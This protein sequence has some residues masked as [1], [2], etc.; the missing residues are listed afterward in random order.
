M[1]IEQ[2]VEI[3][4]RNRTKKYYMDKGYLFTRL[5]DIFS[6]DVKDLIGLPSVLAKYQCDFCNRVFEKRYCDLINK[7]NGSLSK[8]DCCSN[9]NF[10]KRVLEATIR[11]SNGT[12]KSGDPF[13]WYFEEN[14][15]KEL[16]EY[17]EK[18]ESLDDITLSTL[19]NNLNS[20]I[21]KYDGSLDKLLLK[22][23]YNILDFKTKN[24]YG[25]Y[26]NF[27]NLKNRIE[28]LI[29]Q[30]QRFPTLEECDAS[31]LNQFHFK[32]YGGIYE[33]KRMMGYDN[34]DDLIDDRR[35]VNR[36]S[37]EYIVAQFLIH[38][39]VAYSREQNPFPQ[40]GRNFKSDFTLYDSSN[41][42]VHIEL[43]GFE[44]NGNKEI[45]VNYRNNKL[46]KKK[47]YKKYNIHL[48]ELERKLFQDNSYH[49]INE[50]LYEIF[51][52]FIATEYKEIE[53]K[54]FISGRALSDEELL[55]KIMEYSDDDSFL[56]KSSTRE[57]GFYTLYKEIIKRY[58][59]YSLFA[60]KFNK[61]T[62]NKKGSRYSNSSELQYLKNK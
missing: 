33:V 14:R 13:Y 8:K 41:Q 35:H 55:E 45:H 24:I 52:P 1:L 42:P 12:L 11:Q 54:I 50:K 21:V 9:C 10:E 59:R 2:M 20:Y 16:L 25:Y 49:S 58:G 3:K 30:Y 48:I 29:S 46:E 61:K 39:N 5:N 53:T 7:R 23:G 31:G 34:K 19:G 36:S 15:L 27:E 60:K 40:S 56:P 28:S 6:V 43:W 26:S 17:Y 57:Q 38:N 32:Q 18:H 62:I 44:N 47:L 37:Y 22:N 51:K 4:W